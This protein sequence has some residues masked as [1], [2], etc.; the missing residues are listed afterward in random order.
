[1]KNRSGR[2]VQ[3]KARA[4]DLH[5]EGNCKVLGEEARRFGHG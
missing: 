1:M 2:C 3:S 5:A 4:M